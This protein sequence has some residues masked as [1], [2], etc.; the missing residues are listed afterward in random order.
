[1]YT[2][3][4]ETGKVQPSPNLE[5]NDD[6]IICS[7]LT[8]SQNR[9]FTVLVNNFLE[10]PH[11]LKEGCHIATFSI[12]MTPEPPTLIKP[13]NASPLRYLLDPNRNDALQCGHA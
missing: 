8:T 6:L 11:L 2:K 5:D 3:N 1:M 7:A 12:L 10:H 4:E 13:I 9:N